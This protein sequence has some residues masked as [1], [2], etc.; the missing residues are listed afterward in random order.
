VSCA[1][2]V[3]SSCDVRQAKRIDSFCYDVELQ[4]TQRQMY[5]PKSKA[6]RLFWRLQLGLSLTYWR[7]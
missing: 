6:R 5:A 1:H 7:G 4:S 2:D 3:F